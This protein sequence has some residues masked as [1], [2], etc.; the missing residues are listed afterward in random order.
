M[1]RCIRKVNLEV[2]HISQTGGNSLSNAR[3]LCYKCHEAIT[4]YDPYEASPPAFSRDTKDKA[5]AKAG[6]QCEC[7]ATGG[8]H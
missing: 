6:Y 4:V 3:V 5:L 2:R 8:C 1:A 7:T